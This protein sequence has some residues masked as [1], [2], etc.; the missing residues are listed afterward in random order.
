MISEPTR[1]RNLLLQ[2]SGLLAPWDLASTQLWMVH[3]WLSWNRM[4]RKH[5]IELR[6]AEALSHLESSGLHLDLDRMGQEVDGPEW[7]IC[8]VARMVITHLRAAVRS[9]QQRL[10]KLHQIWPPEP[11]L[12][13]STVAFTHENFCCTE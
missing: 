2:G 4:E 5:P 7:I 8:R 6:G 11:L 10:P 13:S 1:W 3:H 9:R 12:E